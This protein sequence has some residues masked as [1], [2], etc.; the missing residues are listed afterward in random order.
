MTHEY[1]LLMAPALARPRP[2]QPLAPRETQSA[3]ALTGSWRYP[4]RPSSRGRIC[5]ALLVSAALHVGVLLVGRSHPRIV[6]RPA[7]D[8]L[9]MVSIPMPDLKDLEQPDSPPDLAVEKPDLGDYA[10][11][12][13]DAPQLVLSSDFVQELNYA[14]LVPP[15]DLSQ[16]KV[17]VIPH[18]INHGAR[19]GEGLGNIFSLADLDHVPEPVFQPAPVFPPQL[20]REVSSARVV[21]EFVVDTEGHV[22]NAIAT[23]STM[24][25][26]ND[27]AVGGVSKWR[28]RAGLRGGRRVNTRMLVPI[29]FSLSEKDY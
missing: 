5:F 6:P 24:E 10:P 25:G 1:P 8:H 13:M 19:L 3:S 7:V 21:V 27:A 12:L 17:F 23:D 2:A 22:R 16:A 20:K 4:G 29:I 26:F 14:S 28:F 9:I 18:T 11:T 15:P